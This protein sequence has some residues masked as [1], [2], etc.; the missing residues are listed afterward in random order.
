MWA[1]ELNTS[2]EETQMYNKYI[3]NASKSLAIE[4]HK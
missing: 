3:Q 4:T 1:N 2:K